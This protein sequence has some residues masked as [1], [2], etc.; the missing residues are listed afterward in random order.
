MALQA[1]RMGKSDEAVDG[2]RPI[3][4]LTDIRTHAV[5]VSSCGIIDRQG[6]RLQRHCHDSSVPL[7]HCVWVL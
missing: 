2:P 5:E 7:G 6:K 1:D 3:V 4:F